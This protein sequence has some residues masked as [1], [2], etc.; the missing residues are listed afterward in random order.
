MHCL[1]RNDR[2]FMSIGMDIY[3]PT[4]YLVEQKNEPVLQIGRPKRK[5]SAIGGR[6]SFFK[7][8][9]SFKKLS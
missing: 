4:N 3:V 8:I 1:V 2:Y 7:D 9:R 5:P 6:L